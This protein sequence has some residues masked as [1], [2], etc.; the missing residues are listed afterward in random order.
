MP[1]RVVRELAGNDIPTFE[2]EVRCLEAVSRQHD[3][4]ATSQARLLLCGAE[5]PAADAGVAPRFIHP[6]EPDFTDTTPRVTAEA[7]VDLAG[8]ISKQHHQQA[9]ITNTSRCEVVLVDLVLEKPEVFRIG[10]VRH[11]DARVLHGSPHAPPNRN[12]NVPRSAK[13]IA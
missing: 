10:I 3:L 2:I 6:E 8:R 11:N 4:L 12:W 9:R 5:Q 13:S 7:R 1:T